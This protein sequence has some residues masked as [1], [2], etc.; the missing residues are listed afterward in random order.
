MLFQQLRPWILAAGIGCVLTLTAG[1]SISSAQETE[2]T[3]QELQQQWKE[4]DAKLVAKETEIETAEGDT[5]A[6]QNEYKTLVEEANS[7][8]EKLTSTAK[9][10]LDSESERTDAVRTLVGVMMNDA[11]LSRDQEA[12]SLGELLIAKEIN[13]DYFK[14]A[15]RSENLS[16][17]AREIFDELLIRH[18]ESKQDDLPRVKFTTTKGDIVI[19]L[20][21]NQAP[22]TVANFISLVENGVYTDMLF[23]R[24]V[25]GFMAQGGG[26]KM[27]G[28]KEV[29]GEGPGYTIKCECDSPEKR[30]HFS[31]S[32]SMA[33]RG[34]DTGG[35]QFFLTFERT[36]FLDGIHTCFGRV[37]DGQ[38]IL[39]DL[40]RT[41]ISRPDRD[42][43]E[44]IPGVVKD[45]I[46]KAEVIRKRD[47]E[48]VPE[49]VADDQESSSPADGETDDAPTG[50][51]Q[52]SGDES[53]G[54][55]DG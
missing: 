52:S 16:I 1:P 15:S 9:S 45:K 33:H 8:V 32:L 31:H 22:N 24:V 27:E 41:H 2:S 50:D 13:P 46:I 55:D 34:K 25:D 29:G 43:E 38:D 53:T 39:S 26:F 5:E 4:L 49:K 44:P 51:E 19:E 36:D 6:I 40:A 11:R 54:Q 3:L 35:S 48:Y 30:L 28:D 23:H 18:N 7:L 17:P 12:L 10:K 20:F 21:E 37:I 14:L 42:E 47:H